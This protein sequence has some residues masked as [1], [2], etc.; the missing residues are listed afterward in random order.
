MKKS[1]NACVCR[2]KIWI[3]IK[4]RQGTTMLLVVCLFLVLC[5]MGMNLL[6]VANANVTNTSREV[7]REQTM[8]YV[9]SIYQIVDEMIIDGKFTDASGAVPTQ[10]TASG[11]EMLVDK[12]G[13]DIAV[14]VKFHSD[15]GRLTAWTQVTCYSREG[16]PET[17]TVKAT[18][19]QNVSGNYERESCEGLVS[20]DTVHEAGGASNP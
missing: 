2:G 19:M 13:R 7:E 8:F 20:N 18:Y 11:G 9:S 10:V 12:N 4:E 14:V 15:G 6:N 17:Y 16:Q 3:K 5:V 1:K